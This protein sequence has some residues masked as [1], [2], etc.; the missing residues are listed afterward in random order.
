M[1]IS[2]DPE[3][4]AMYI[5]LSSKSKDKQ[6]EINDDVILD[7]SNDGSVVG[8]EILDAT[9]NYSHDILD[10]NLSFLGDLS[11]PGQLDYT[12]DEAAEILQVNKE[13]ILRKIRV[14]EL[15]A[16]RLGKSYR[17]PKNE[18]HRLMTP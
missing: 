2:Y 13:T 17:I 8:I 16:S 5:Q 6:Q 18:I 3:V 4:D 15:K 7:L 12:A 9:A 1:R 11:K 14:G 10:F